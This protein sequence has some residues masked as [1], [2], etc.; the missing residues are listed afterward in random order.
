L[1]ARDRDLPLSFAQERMWFAQQLEPDATHYNT[2]VAVRV[3]GALSLDALARTLSE[4]V[5]RHESLRTVFVEDGGVARQRI[6]APFDVPV[7]ALDVASAPGATPDLDGARATAARWIATPFDLRNGPLVRAASLRLGDD[8]DD[9]VVVLAMHHIVTDGW[10]LGILIREVTALYPA[11]AAG[12]PPALPPLALQYADVAVWQRQWLRG[13]ALDRELPTTFARPTRPSVRGAVHV[14]RVSAELAAGVREL[15]RRH[16]ATLFMTLLAGFDVLL[17]RYCRQDDV[18]VGTPVANRGY[19]GLEPLVGCFIN[20]LV[21][22]ADLSGEPSFAQFLD[23]VR[24]RTLVAYAHQD[25]PFDHLVDALQVPRDLGRNPL[26]QVLFMLQNTIRD[27]LSVP[28]LA[29]SELDLAMGTVKFDL[30]LMVHD[31][32]DELALHW[33]YRSELFDEPS[34]AAMARQYLALLA[35]V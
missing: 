29:F 22:R 11:I 7:A 2:A 19:P 34:V 27:E 6:A 23:R 20:T 30:A 14:Q 5:R 24:K 18:C 31:M 17:G 15:S 4:L 35:A 9:H 28:G 3:Q 26:F 33:Q 12:R 8:D 10:S 21:L 1:V 25:L 13:A 16:G 32:G